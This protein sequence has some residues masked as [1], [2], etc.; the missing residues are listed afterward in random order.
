VDWVYFV[1]ARQAAVAAAAAAL[2]R[3]ELMVWATAAVMVVL[4]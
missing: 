4:A 1:V 3:L 2:V